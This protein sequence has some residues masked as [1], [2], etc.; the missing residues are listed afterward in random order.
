MMDERFVTN[1]RRSEGH[2]SQ[3]PELVTYLIMSDNDKPATFAAK[4]MLDIKLLITTVTP[5]RKT[6]RDVV[7]SKKKSVAELLGREYRCV[8]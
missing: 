6:R 5:G 8:D 2:R 4:S 1:G 3:V 7:D